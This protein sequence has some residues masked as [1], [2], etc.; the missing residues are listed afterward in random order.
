VSSNDDEDERT[1]DERRETRDEGRK[2][3]ERPVRSVYEG[4]RKE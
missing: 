2:M 3:K 1:A 4:R